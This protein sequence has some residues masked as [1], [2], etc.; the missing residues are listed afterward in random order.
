M[1]TKM[2]GSRNLKSPGRL[3]R[4]IILLFGGMLSILLFFMVPPHKEWLKERIGQYWDDFLTQRD[5]QGLEQRKIKRFESH[6]T[7]SK[8]IADLL[9]QKGD[10][11]SAWVLLPPTGYFKKNGIDYEVPDPGVFYYFTDIKTLSANNI[12]AIQA[13]WYVR[14]HN[15]QIIVDSVTNRDSLKDT[16]NYFRSIK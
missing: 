7:L 10:K 12:Q 16:I 15:K 4:R 9:A 14:V 11:K 2:P 5:Q 1:N 6:Y 13:N 3:A 8:Q